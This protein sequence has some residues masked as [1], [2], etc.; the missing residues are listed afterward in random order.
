MTAD[1]E[2]IHP[3]SRI[4]QAAEQM[5]LLDVG[6][7]PVVE[8][9]IVVGMITDRDIVVRVIAEHRDPATTGVRHAMTPEVI[10]CFEDQDIQEAARLMEDWQVRRLIVL[11]RDGR[12]A[13]IVSIG[14]LALT[15]G[16]DRMTGEVIERVSEPAPSEFAFDGGRIDPDQGGLAR[17]A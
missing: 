14:D 16:D 1:V 11:G 15:T 6:P 8:G 7:L 4:V 17:S 3:D 12:L 2:T 5:A 13:G 10:S 9:G